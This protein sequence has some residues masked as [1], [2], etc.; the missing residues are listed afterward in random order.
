MV[1]D[2]F[3]EPQSML[4]GRINLN[5]YLLQNRGLPMLELVIDKAP[6]PDARKLLKKSQK[7][8]IKNW[9]VGI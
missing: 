1:D 7:Q 9:K 6:R 8:T 5:Q 4:Q 3:V 2:D